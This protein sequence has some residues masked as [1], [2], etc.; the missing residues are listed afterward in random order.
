[1]YKSLY[2]DAKS[3][4]WFPVFGISANYSTMI[5]ED[6]SMGALAE[7]GSE[8]PE[9]EYLFIAL[10][11]PMQN[12][13]WVGNP[14]LKQPLRGT[15]RGSVNYQK[16]R[17]EIFATRV[18]NYINLA[19]NVAGRKPY[20]TYENVN[21]YLFGINFGFDWKFI[22]L[23]ASYTYVQNTTNNSPLSEIQPL[24]INAK[25]TSPVL[26]NTTVYLKYTYNDAQTRVDFSLNETTTPAWNRI[27]VGLLYNAESILISIEVENLTN[28]LYYQHLSY[29]R[30][31]FASG[32]RVFEPGR[33]VRLNF[34]FNQ[35][36]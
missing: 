24:S 30:D 17:M 19:N 4:R 23:N 18:W 16:F 25:I 8:A 28:T 12:P 3:S 29:L 14:T 2:P 1:M 11:K 10:Q 6:W 33:T 13:N 21:A 31:P 26:Y 27:D 22:N 35:I 36:L 15:V 5:N 9:T 32:N 7:A 34:R 20:T